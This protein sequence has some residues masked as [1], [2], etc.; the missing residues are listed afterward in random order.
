MIRSIKLIPKISIRP[1]PARYTQ[2]IRRMS[3]KTEQEWKSSLTPEQYHVLRQKGTERPF[4]GEYTDYF[5]E[6]TYNCAA[7]GNPLYDSS[8]KFKSHCGWASFWAARPDSI[9]L[10]EDN[11]HGMQR[12][13]I[14]CAKSKSHIGHLF[15]EY[16]PNNPTNDRHC[17]N[18]VSL[19]FVPKAEN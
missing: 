8:T 14:L 5:A 9:I 2:I 4:T 15:H 1:L 12:T 18:S 10:Q 13:E 19:K 11:S 6:G 7:C 3:D 17:V 16:Y